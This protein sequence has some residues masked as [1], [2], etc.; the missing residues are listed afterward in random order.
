MRLENTK[1]DRSIKGSETA[2]EKTILVDERTL[3]AWIKAS[4]SMISLR[5]TIYKLLQEMKGK[6]ESQPKPHAPGV[7]GDYNNLWPSYA[8]GK[9]DPAS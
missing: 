1:T 2:I 5:F 4:V 6:P 7:R 8:T 9:R 3:M